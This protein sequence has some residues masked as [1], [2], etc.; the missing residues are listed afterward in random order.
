MA[1][2]STDRSVVIQLPRDD[3]LQRA[4][5]K[6]GALEELVKSMMGAQVGRGVDNVIVRGGRSSGPATAGFDWTKT[7]WRRA[8]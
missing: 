5:L 4:K 2:K 1:R 6:A 7:I 8:C 3:Q